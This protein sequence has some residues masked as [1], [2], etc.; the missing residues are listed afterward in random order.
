MVCNERA[1]IAND[2][3]LSSNQSRI[4][5]IA[6][7]GFYKLSITKDFNTADNDYSRKPRFSIISVNSIKYVINV[8][9]ER[10]TKL[11]LSEN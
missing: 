7:T 10:K 3:N 5:N 1:S 8:L 6:R 4:I 2:I 11:E 9:E